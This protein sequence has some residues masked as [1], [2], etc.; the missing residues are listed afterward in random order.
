V[1]L[2]QTQE[3][4]KEAQ[5]AHNEAVDKTYELLRNLLSRD[6][7]T[8]WDQICLKMHERDLW[9]GVNSLTTTE[10][11]HVC[12]LLSET[13]MSCISSQSSLLMRPKGSRSTFSRWCASPRGPLC[14]SISC[15]WECYPYLPT[16]KDCPKSVP[17]TKKGNIPISK[18][19]LATI[20]SVPMTWQNQ[21]NLTQLT[22]C[23]MLCKLLLDLKN[24][25]RVMVEKKN[26]K[27]KAKGKYSTACPAAKSNPKRKAFGGL[28]NQV[29][30]KAC[31]EKFCQHCKAHS[32]PYQTHNTSDCHC[33][34]KDGKP[35][36]V[37]T[38]KP[39]ESKKPYK[40]I[41]GNKSMAFM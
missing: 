1:E 40:K 30:K 38:G 26:E 17:T 20:A 33:N 22:V 16:L 7:Q 25:K 24:I 4:L 35:L 36:W 27:L 12:G 41:G 21:Y 39:C 9:A 5:K 13:V 14:I 18:A 29:P 6:L 3:M 15:V 32:S 31:S 11:V 34:D 10:G 28:S 2:S 8:Q 23:K 19:D 37:A